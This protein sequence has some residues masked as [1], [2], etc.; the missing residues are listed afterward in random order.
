MRV[1]TLWIDNICQELVTRATSKADRID[2]TNQEF[3]QLLFKPID[4]PPHLI[5]CGQS[6]GAKSLN[7]IAQGLSMAYP[8]STAIYITSNKDGFNRGDLLKNGFAEAFLI[9]FEV[10]EFEKFVNSIES[11][12]SS[13]SSNFYRSVKL[14]DFQGDEPL[15]FDT[16]VYLPLN[17][18]YIRYTHAG[19]QL[20]TEQV[21]RLKS[22]D[23]SSLQIKQADMPKFYQF[24]AQKLVAMGQSEGLSETEK[25][26]KMQSAVRSIVSGVFSET[27]AGSGFDPGRKMIADCQEIVKAYI[28]ASSD[29]P[30]ATSLYEKISRIAQEDSGLYSYATNTATFGGLFS[31]GLG[32]GDP[33]EISMAGLLCDVGLAALPPE[34]QIKKKEE[35]TKEDENMY[36]MHPELSVN[37]LKTKRMILPEKVLKMIMQ[38][39]ENYDGTGYPNALQ[40]FK[41]LPEAQVLGIAS[42]FSELLMMKP[43]QKRTSPREAIEYIRK[44]LSGTRFDPILVRKIYEMLVPPEEQ[45]SDSA[46]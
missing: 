33:E 12:I 43:G 26:D 41:I 1:L 45:S 4:P 29:E 8:S 27:S 19:K 25:R 44:N 36:R 34:V 16:Y 20:N 14:V 11:K 24:T 15:D 21:K 9:P 35:R 40:H 2:G 10:T 39:H 32:I 30:G 37:L 23:V 3:N 5:M 28:I 7:E 42:D 17:G 18:K 13:A 46:A 31:I 6:T 22:H 38:H